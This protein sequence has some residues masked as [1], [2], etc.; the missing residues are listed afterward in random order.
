MLRK[1]YDVLGWVMSLGGSCAILEHGHDISPEV[2]VAGE[3]DDGVEVVI[4]EIE[5][6]HH[7]VCDHHHFGPLGGHGESKHLQTTRGEMK[8]I[9]IKQT[10]KQNR[11]HYRTT[12]TVY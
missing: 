4:S 7:L 10:V 11:S 3:V 9:N 1:R 8:Y 5:G 2:H 12:I 6:V